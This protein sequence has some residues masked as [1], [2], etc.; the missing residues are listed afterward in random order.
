M[1]EFLGIRVKIYILPSREIIPRVRY[2][3][4]YQQPGKAYHLSGITEKQR[5]LYAMMDV[6]VPT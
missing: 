2:N 4:N 5:N 3:L 6:A 1:P